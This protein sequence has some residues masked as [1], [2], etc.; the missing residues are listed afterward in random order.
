MSDTTM[1]ATN[2]SC[3]MK[4]RTAGYSPA[5]RSERS[6]RPRNSG[7][8]SLRDAHIRTTF[9]NEGVLAVIKMEAIA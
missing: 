3:S 9:K 1:A 7:S 4:M 2:Y 8:L 6:E 5:M